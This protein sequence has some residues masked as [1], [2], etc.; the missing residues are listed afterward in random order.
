[1]T[2]LTHMQM[3]LHLMQEFQQ[4]DEYLIIS[5]MWVYNPFQPIRLL[6]TNKAVQY[7]IRTLS[8]SL[9]HHFH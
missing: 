4:S 6:I 3:A 8:Y 5:I 1:M 7:K 9:Q 2:T